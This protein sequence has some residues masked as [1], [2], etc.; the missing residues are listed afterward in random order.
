MKWFVNQTFLL[1]E[2]QVIETEHLNQ[3]KDGLWNL[4]TGK[5]RERS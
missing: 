5:S 1:H 4:E 3:Q 2:L